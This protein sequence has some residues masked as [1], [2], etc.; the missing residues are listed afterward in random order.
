MPK[1]STKKRQDVEPTSVAALFGEEATPEKDTDLNAKKEDEAPK[2]PT[3]EELLARL[4]AMDQRMQ[5]FGRTQMAATQPIQTPTITAPAE[6]KLD[7]SNMPDPV[8]A[9]ADYN[10][11]LSERV[12]K[13]A[14][15]RL[16]WES[17]KR[18]ST[19][20]AAES[21]KN[22]ADQLWTDFSTKYSDYAEDEEKVE[23]AMQSVVKNAQKRGIDLERYM[24]TH[25]DQ[26]M[27]DVVTKMDNLFGKPGSAKAEEDEEEAV[28]T[29]M[30]AHGSVFPSKV[31]KTEDAGGDF[32]SEIHEMQRKSGFY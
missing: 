8:Y 22:R 9:S 7:M 11:V 28:R 3:T 32:I 5:E 10:R 19:A 31:T 20:S 24:F 4:E 29:V 17:N 1:V 2:G 27:R 15:D 26:F 30:P 16:E 23:L 14:Q 13:F 6:P 12:S 25:Q 21:Q 18:Q